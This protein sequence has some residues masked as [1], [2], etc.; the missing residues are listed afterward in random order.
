M[1]TATNTY[2]RLAFVRMSVTGRV[3]RT[4]GMLGRS[5]QALRPSRYDTPLLR[6]VR[7]L[8]PLD[9]QIV[10]IQKDYLVIKLPKRMH[11]RLMWALM[12]A[13]GKNK[14]VVRFDRIMGKR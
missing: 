5:P 1:P 4:G 7:E 9:T 8:L 11:S 2:T 10:E 14:I 12:R 3:F 6:R 13:L